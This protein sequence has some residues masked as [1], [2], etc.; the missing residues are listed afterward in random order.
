MKTFD[1]VVRDFVQ[2]LSDASCNENVFLQISGRQGHITGIIELGNRRRIFTAGGEWVSD[3]IQGLSH[4]W[5]EQNVIPKTTLAPEEIEHRIDALDDLTTYAWDW[6]RHQVN[7]VMPWLL[8]EI[9]RYRQL[10]EN[11]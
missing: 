4:K 10:M 3:V 6:K 9:G 7:R 1:E 11:M 8:R 2:D 5:G